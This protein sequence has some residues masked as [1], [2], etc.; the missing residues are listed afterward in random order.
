[1]APIRHPPWADG[2]AQMTY[3]GPDGAQLLDRIEGISKVGAAF[4]SPGDPLWDTYPVRKGGQCQAWL[5][6]ICR[7]DSVAFR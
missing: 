5:Q 6:T 3:K 7:F 2:A 1:L 4:R